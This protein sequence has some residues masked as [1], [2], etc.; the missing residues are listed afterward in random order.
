MCIYIYISNPLQDETE[1]GRYA[2]LS[3]GGPR[4]VFHALRP[5][6]NAIQVCFG[7]GRWETWCSHCSKDVRLSQFP[8]NSPPKKGALKSRNQSWSGCHVKIQNGEPLAANRPRSPHDAVIICYHGLSLLC[9]HF[10]RCSC[11]WSLRP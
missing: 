4:G 10:D 9:F 5:R 7:H 3:A 2:A 1:I 6:L 11:P 8:L